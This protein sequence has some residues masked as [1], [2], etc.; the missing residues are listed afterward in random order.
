MGSSHGD[1]VKYPR[2][3]HL[4]GSKGTDDDKHLGEAQFARERCREY[5]R[6][7]TDFAFNA[8]NLMKTTR[9]RWIDL[10]ADY[11]ARVELVY[12]EPPFQ[13]LLQQNRNRAKSVPEEVVRQLAGKCEP[14]NSTECH[15]L[16]FS[17]GWK[18]LE[19]TSSF[20]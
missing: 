14:P 2:T 18:E 3:P 10:F 6:S 12:V 5:L 15:G 20:L 19:S 4:F 9:Q 11:R 8:T 17:D 13:R 7:R 16:V 1:F